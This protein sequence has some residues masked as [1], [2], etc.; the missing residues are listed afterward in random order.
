MHVYRIARSYQ[1]AEEGNVEYFATLDHAHKAAK[2]WPKEGW[3]FAMIELFDVPADRHSL[4]ALLNGNK[5]KTRLR[6]WE[7][8]DRGGLK[9][10]IAADDDYVPLA[11]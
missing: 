2:Q 1:S 6:F 7:L 3:P 4:I 10:D 11:V 5:F 8:T 9:E